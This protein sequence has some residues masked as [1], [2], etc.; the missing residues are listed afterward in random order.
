MIIK[1]DITDVSG[2]SYKYLKEYFEEL[3][4]V[5]V[6]NVI[7]F[8]VGLINYLHN[9]FPIF[10]ITVSCL[11]QVVN[12]AAVDFY[13]NFNVRRIVYPRHISITEAVSIAQKYPDIEFEAF[14]LFEKCAFD[15][16]NCRCIHNAGFICHDNYC[17][18]YIIHDKKMNEAIL[19]KNAY[20]YE[21]GLI[22]IMI[23]TGTVCTILDVLFAHYIICFK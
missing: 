16:G 5:N 15:D 13:K 17:K 14:S 19:N 6:K 8:D 22:L 23:Q 20:L 2:V 1:N 11:N 7:V 3:T 21:N 10:M 9:N 4:S 18:N 12:C